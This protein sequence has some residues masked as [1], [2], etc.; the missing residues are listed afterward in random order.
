M[1]D[2]FDDMKDSLAETF[3][4]EGT[5]GTELSAEQFDML[6]SFMGFYMKELKGSIGEQKEDE[7]FRSLERVDAQL[8]S[9]KFAGEMDRVIY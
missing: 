4:Q 8:N 3:E 2:L 7:S 9:L 1:I 6:H 5:N